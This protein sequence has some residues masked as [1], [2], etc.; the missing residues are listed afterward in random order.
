[1]SY[2]VAGLIAIT[3]LVSGCNNDTGKI[4]LKEVGG[5]VYLIDNETK[6]ISRLKG[7]TLHEIKF[8]SDYWHP[9][10][11][12][13]KD[14]LIEDFITVNVGL[15]FIDYTTY[16]KIELTAKTLPK[17]VTFDKD[18][19]EK[20]STDYLNYNRMEQKVSSGSI[21]LNFNNQQGAH[22]K[23]YTVKLTDPIISSNGPNFTPTLVYTGYFDS[24][25]LSSKPKEPITLSIHY[26]L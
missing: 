7:D 23:S 20:Q 12:I 1:M 4:D 14:W 17:F 22:L 18:G 25:R 15:E 5:R 9:S 26:T 3:A 6:K 2:R 8:E 21:T 24:L 10:N 19:N 11:P 13:T 16:Y